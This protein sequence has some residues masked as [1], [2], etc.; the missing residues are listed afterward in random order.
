M[1]LIS[2]RWAP[3]HVVPLVLAANRDEY[4]QRSSL[5]AQHW[6]ENTAIFAGKDLV[7]AGTWLG[8]NNKTGRLAVITN[9]RELS[10]IEYESS[11][12]RIVSDYLTTTQEST[13]WL[14]DLLKKGDDYAGFN[15][16]VGDVGGLYYVSNRESGIRTL[17]PGIYGFSNGRWED[18]WPKV[19]VLNRAMQKETTHLKQRSKNPLRHLS[20]NLMV[21]LNNQ[22]CFPDNML[23]NTG[24]GLPVERKRSPCFI[25]GEYYGTRTSTVIM[26]EKKGTLHWH[27]QHYHPFGKLAEHYAHTLPLSMKKHS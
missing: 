18:R 9:Y 16:L 6:I 12:G 25:S 2:I 24:V 21:A 14:L 19:D 15:L 10:K 13:S 1:C 22:Q 5:P 4:Y 11:R 17:V 3:E 27:E 8:I 20:E 26:L 23:P 7:G